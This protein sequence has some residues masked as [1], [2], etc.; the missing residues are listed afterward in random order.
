MLVGLVWGAA[1][2]PLQAG[3]YYSGEHQNELPAQWGG[4][5]SDLRLLRSC[6]VPGTGAIPASDLRLQYSEAADAL[7][8]LART[9]S[10]S[11]DEAAD[12][13]ALL[14]RLGQ[15][16]QALAVL[17]PAH[18]A[19]PDHFRLTA[20]LGTA[21]QLAG[22][23]DQA[24]VY[25]KE[26]VRLAPP[27]K[28]RVEELHWK[29][30]RGRRTARGGL[31]DL[32]GVRLEPGTQPALP[33]DAL[34]ATQQLLI[35]LPSD[36]LLLWQL[37]EL[38]AALGDL[39]GGRDMLEIAVGEF[40]LSHPDLRAHRLKIRN[41]IT[42][43]DRR[44]LLN[45]KV[46]QAAHEGHRSVIGFKSRRPLRLERYDTRDLPLV[47]KTEVN[48]VPWGVFLQTT[49]DRRY[50]PTFTK[51]LEELEGCKVSLTGF[52]H[53]VTDDLE[54][55]VFLI[56]EMPVGCWYCEMPEVTGI[57]LVEM[58]GDKSVPLTRNVLQVTGR[59]RLNRTDPEDFF[60][61]IEQAEASELN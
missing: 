57:V 36:G 10:L 3:L 20:N 21:W 33:P 51:Y 58:A 32:F 42:E 43:Q 6:A 22:D 56:V 2:G 53:P 61:I 41:L 11:A 52:M 60:F 50:R 14:V 40:G 31:D 13:G 29:L 35:W 54:A 46:Q 8:A 4:L 30:V 39:R 5:L 1:A 55:A 9:R 17:R 48:A 15:V 47:S 19:Q 49:V 24:E 59:L 16:P 45:L 28:Q 26:A 18:A 25:L 12:L 23:L 44:E 34:A 7:K 37:G 38:A 27:A